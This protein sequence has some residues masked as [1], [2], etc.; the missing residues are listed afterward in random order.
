MRTLA[1]TL[2]ALLGGSFPAAAADSKPGNPD[3]I[4]V[5]DLRDPE[6]RKYQAIVAGLDAFDQYHAMAPKVAA[7]RFRIEPRGSAQQAT[8]PTARLG[9]NDGFSLA[10]PVGADGMF[11]VPRSQA[12]LDAGAELVLN[13]KRRDYKVTP[14]VRSPGLPENVRRLGDLRLE[15]RVQVAIAKEEIPLWIVLTAN[16][17]LRTRDWCGFTIDGDKVGFT[18][19]HGRNVNGA[20]LVDGNR[21]AN[22][23]TE[24]RGF[25]VPI[26]DGRWSDDALIELDLAEASA[27]TGTDAGTPRTGP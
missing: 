14:T 26:G 3:E 16:T 9:G 18:F 21:S 27:L 19:R 2:A 6:V 22:L 23:E 24:G 11:V 1:L 4:K 17:V 10:L 20:V 7:V 13:Q 5:N 15:C 25:R 8:L 12:A